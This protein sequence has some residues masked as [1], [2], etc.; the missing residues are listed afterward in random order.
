MNKQLA[1]VQRHYVK[2]TSYQGVAIHHVD[3]WMNMQ[4]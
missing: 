4:P 3:S 2:K 1:L